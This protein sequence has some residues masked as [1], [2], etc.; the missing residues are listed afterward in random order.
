[1]ICSLHSH[2]LTSPRT[3]LTQ[4]PTSTVRVSSSNLAQF[5]GVAD[6]A[7]ALEGVVLVDTALGAL[8]AARTGGT[9]VYLGLTLQTDEPGPTRA[10]EPCHT[11]RARSAGSKTPCWWLVRPTIR[12][13]CESLDRRGSV[14]RNQ[15]GAIGGVNDNSNVNDTE[16]KVNI[17][18][19]WLISRYFFSSNI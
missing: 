8:G 2:T 19:A 9:L 3:Q 15:Y 16:L 13:F 14:R 18:L 5:A 7:L 4:L 10:D 17:L 11:P 6:A 1:M 12:C